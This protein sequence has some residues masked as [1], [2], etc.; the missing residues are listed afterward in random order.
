MLIRSVVLMSLFLMVSSG[1]CF[2]NDVVDEPAYQNGECWTFKVVSG[3]YIGYTTRDIP[4]GEHRVCF[5]NGA[6]ASVQNGKRYRLSNFWSFA[7]PLRSGIRF[8]SSI[9]SLL[10]WVRSGRTSMKGCCGEPIKK[11]DVPLK[12][13]FL[14]GSPLRYRLAQSTVLK[15]SEEFGIKADGIKA[16][17]LRRLHSSGVRKRKLLSNTNM[18]H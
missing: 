6:F 14:V 5:V 10:L 4:D 1:V 2:G 13:R 8:G 3:K 9:S 17:W 12:A 7:F 15:S 16:E 18:R 11:F